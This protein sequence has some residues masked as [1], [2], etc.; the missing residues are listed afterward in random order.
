[1]KSAGNSKVISQKE[2]CVLNANINGKFVLVIV[3]MCVVLIA[4][5]AMAGTTGKIT[6]RVTDRETGEPILGA[7]VMAVGHARGENRAVLAVQRAV[8][9]RPLDVSV[10]GACGML[11]IIMGGQDL[12]LFEIV[13]RPRSSD[14]RCTLTRASSL[15][16]PLM[17]P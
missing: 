8:S 14:G 4:S 12:T 15:A 1:M 17:I 11:F 16:L 7:A 6:G 2:G 13:K 5:L 9:N 3:A 10:D